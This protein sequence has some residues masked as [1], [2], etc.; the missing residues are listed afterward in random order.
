MVNKPF[1]ALFVFFLSCISLTLFANEKKVEV[2]RTVSAQSDTDTAHSYFTS[3][4]SLAL[5]LSEPKFGEAQLVVSSEPMTQGRWFRLLDGSAYLDV[6]WAGASIARDV[7][8]RLIPVD[9]LGGI[10]GIRAV[11]IRKSDRHKFLAIKSREDLKGLTAC[12][13]QHW[14]DTAILEAAQL[15][16]LTVNKFESNFLMLSKGRCDYFPRGIHEG[17]SEIEQYHM[18]NGNDL[19]IFDDFLIT[20]PF[21]MWFY[22]D[23]DNNALAERLT[24]GLEM[25]IANGSFLKLMQEHAVTSH[26]FPLKKWNNRTLIQLSNPLHRPTDGASS[27]WLLE[28]YP[29]YQQLK[30]D[31]HNP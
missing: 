29:F 21:N 26:L 4:I 10:L 3:L 18:L 6:V 27:W 16:V 9:L 14:P 24:Y 15:S 12:Q 8:Y 22:V 17:Y 25:A 19:V 13:G 5:N 28:K 20:Y 11:I 1:K 31:G 23:K 2:V 30:W 7:D